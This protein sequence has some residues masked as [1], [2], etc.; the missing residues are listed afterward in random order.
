MSEGTIHFLQPF[1]YLVNYTAIVIG[2]T[3]FPACFDGHLCVSFFFF[4]F[5][6]FFPSF[7]PL[8]LSSE[9]I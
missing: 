6:F 1:S 3:W 9:L 4:F 7:S 2:P 5:F 8:S